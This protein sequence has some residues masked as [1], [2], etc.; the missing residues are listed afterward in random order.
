MMELTLLMSVTM[1]A[2]AMKAGASCQTKG[3]RH[4]VFTRAMSLLETQLE[5]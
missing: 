4:P 2:M 5:R 1:F 3:T